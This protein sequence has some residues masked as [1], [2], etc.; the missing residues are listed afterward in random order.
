MQL[1]FEKPADRNLR[2]AGN[3]I[4]IFSDGTGQY[5]GL[6]PDQRLSNI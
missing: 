1:E 5:G 2:S 3:N 4:L 6:R